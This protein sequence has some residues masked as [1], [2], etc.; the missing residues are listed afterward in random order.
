MNESGTA[1][2]FWPFSLATY[3]R[4]GVEAACL[5]L[6]DEFGL[7]VN[8]LLFCCWAARAGFGRLNAEEL[9]AITQL[10][11][12]WN[13][14]V[15][16]PLRQVRRVLKDRVGPAPDGPVAALRQ[17]VKDVELEAEWHEQR[18]LA[19]LMTRA[20]AA[21]ISRDAAHANLDAYI[22]AVKGKRHPA[23]DAHLHTLVEAA[24]V[25]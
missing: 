13:A 18:M 22:A 10:A 7:D 11:R 20:A 5:V 17:A 23:M 25:N 15:V 1:P 16:A 3:R 21:P 12:D 24:F 2:E 6:Q 19:D 14:V 8:C 9:G 4:P